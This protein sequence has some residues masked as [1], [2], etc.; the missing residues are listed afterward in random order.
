MRHLAIYIC[1][2]DIGK[3]YTL[4]KKLNIVFNSIT[5]TKYHWQLSNN[6][7][8]IVIVLACAKFS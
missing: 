7:K 6:V 8:L 5:K 3:T 4:T 1:E 2:I